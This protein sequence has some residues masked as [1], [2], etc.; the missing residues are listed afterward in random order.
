MVSFRNIVDEG[1]RHRRGQV[2]PRRIRF[3]QGGPSQ[4]QRSD[5]VAVDQRL[6]GEARHLHQR[7]ASQGG[8]EVRVAGRAAGVTLTLGLFLAQIDIQR[9]DAIGR[10][11]DELA[12]GA[13]LEPAGLA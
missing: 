13:R 2:A 3:A 12:I 9:P 11:L 1:R 4:T 10:P 7:L 6:H 8:V 5:D